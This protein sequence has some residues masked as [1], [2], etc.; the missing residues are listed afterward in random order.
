MSL[1]HLVNTHTYILT[2]DV[3]CTTPDLLLLLLKGIYLSHPPL[4]RLSYPSSLRT[5]PR[6][7]ILGLPSFLTISCIFLQSNNSIPSTQHYPFTI[8]SFI[9]YDLLFSNNTLISAAQLPYWLLSLS[10]L[11]HPQVAK[12]YWAPCSSLHLSPSPP[13]LSLYLLHIPRFCISYSDLQAIC[14]DHS[15]RLLIQSTYDLSRV[16]LFPLANHACNHQSYYANFFRFTDFLLLYHYLYMSIITTLYRTCLLH[17]LIL[18]PRIRVWPAASIH[19]SFV[20]FSSASLFRGGGSIVHA[21]I[22]SYIT[23]H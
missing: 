11:A 23:S 22:T 13:H 2:F 8:F 12:H 20:S 15:Y 3:I 1:E 10:P 14:S 17:A 5:P 4:V 7:L 18:Q 16:L 6:Y 19:H 9:I 21:M